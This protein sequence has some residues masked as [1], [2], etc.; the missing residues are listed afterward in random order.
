MTAAAR[1]EAMHSLFCIGDYSTQVD[2]KLAQLRQA[3][4]VVNLRPDCLPVDK[5]R[6]RGLHKAGPPS[7]QGTFA[8]GPAS[9]MLRTGY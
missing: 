7:V 5:C 2:T 3:D 6:R 1:S 8:S 4:S 9:R